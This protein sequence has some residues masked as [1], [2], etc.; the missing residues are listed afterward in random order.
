MP[1][2]GEKEFKSNELIEANRST[3]SSIWKEEETKCRVEQ[4]VERNYN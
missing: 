2:H 3:E 4:E 1:T